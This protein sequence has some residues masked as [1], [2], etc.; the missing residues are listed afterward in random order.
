MRHSCFF[1]DKNLVRRTKPTYVCNHMVFKCV[2]GYLCPLSSQEPTLIW[3]AAAV[4]DLYGYEQTCIAACNKFV[5]T[6]FFWLK[7]YKIGSSK[8]DGNWRAP[9][10]P[11]LNDYFVVIFKLLRIYSFCVKKCPCVFFFHKRGS[12]AS[13]TF[14]KVHPPP[15][16][17]SHPPPSISLQ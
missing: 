9:C 8:G 15:P 4:P 6:K 5:T 16:T 17:F 2:N 13:N 3:F 10:K 11:A 7:Q 12:K 14:L 1:F